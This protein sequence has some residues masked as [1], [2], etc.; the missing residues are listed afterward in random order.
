[1]RERIAYRWQQFGGGGFVMFGSVALKGPRGPIALFSAHDSREARETETTRSMA[2]RS[3]GRRAYGGRSPE[4][5]VEGRHR[6]SRAQ[7]VA[8]GARS[9]RDR[10]VAASMARIAPPRRRETAR[11][12]G[13]S[14]QS[15]HASAFSLCAIAWTSSDSTAKRCSLPTDSISSAMFGQSSSASFTSSP[16]ARRRSN[17]PLTLRP[18]HYVLLV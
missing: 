16:A 18:Q 15:G 17:S 13:A 10:T 6:L 3:R 4:K 14:R 12:V 2:P 9:G 7:P 8:R 1:M 5:L 11:H